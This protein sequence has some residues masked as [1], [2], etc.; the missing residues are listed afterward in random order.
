MIFKGF[1]VATGVI[2]SGCL[3]SAAAVVMLSKAKH[4]WLL[5]HAQP[6]RSDQR[7]LASL[8]MTNKELVRHLIAC[9]NNVGALDHENYRS[10]RRAR[11]MAHAFRHDEALSRPKINDAIFEIDQEPPI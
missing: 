3:A 8:G 5:A 10:F 2:C 11:T 6:G 4:L 9:R 7:F 1:A